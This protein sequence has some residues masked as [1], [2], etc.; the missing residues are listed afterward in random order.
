MREQKEMH[1]KYEESDL[2]DDGGRLA[3]A[4]RPLQSA[5]VDKARENHLMMGES[6]SSPAPILYSSC[7][8][9]EGMA[10]VVPF[11]CCSLELLCWSSESLTLIQL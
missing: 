2:N 6:Q 3:C 1:A 7:K 10:C 5:C 9:K 4:R 8:G 11:N